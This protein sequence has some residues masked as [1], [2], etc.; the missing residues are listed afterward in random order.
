[1]IHIDSHQ[2]RCRDVAVTLSIGPRTTLGVLNPIRN[3]ARG[4]GASGALRS[5]VLR[6]ASAGK[7]RVIDKPTPQVFVTNISLRASRPERW[8]AACVVSSG[9]WSH[10]IC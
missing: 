8:E 4:S 5:S 6:T 10:P 9:S 1:M 3:P 7:I 2:A